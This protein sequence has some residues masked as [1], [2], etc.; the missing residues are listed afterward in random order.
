MD[1]AIAAISF[2]FPGV[3]GVRCAFGM[4]ATPPARD[5]SGGDEPADPFCGGNISYRVGDDPERVT[6]TRRAFQKALGFSSWHSLAQV[7]GADM[8]FDPDL[9]TLGETSVTR[10]DGQAT[11]RPGA[12]LVIKTA[13]C[14]PILLAH[15]SGRHVAALHA[16]WRG[17]VMGF[18]ASG[19]AAFCARYGLSPADC[20]AVRGPSLG[21]GASEVINFEKEFGEEFAAYFDPAARTVDLWRLTRDQ[22]AGAGLKP[23][24][25]FGLDLCTASSRHFFSYR[26]SRTTGRQAAFIWIAR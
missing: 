3:P 16:G 4:R 13:D 8:V 15:A 9:D 23:E 14:Q 12:A 17:N 11:S 25:I 6:R 18:P 21:P 20:L 24:N 10:A 2:T 26:R 1:Q 22:L 7:H 19:V 5:A